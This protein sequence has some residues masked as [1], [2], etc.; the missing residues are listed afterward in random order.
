ML[1]VFFFGFV[2]EVKFN[3]RIFF[4]FLLALPPQHEREIYDV[5]NV[6]RVSQVCEGRERFET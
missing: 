3:A 2:F 4:F 1:T 6:R 5:T